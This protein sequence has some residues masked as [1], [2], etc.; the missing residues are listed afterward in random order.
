MTSL[1]VCIVCMYVCTLMCV[2][3]YDLLLS[4]IVWQVCMYVCIVCMYVYMHARMCVFM[5]VCVLCMYA[6]IFLCMYICMTWM[7]SPQPES[8][9]MYI[10]L[11][12]V[13]CV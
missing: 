2:Y 7:A 13:F 11:V 5:N 9:Y 1:Y 6:C 12:S 4:R 10:F 8:T 3:M